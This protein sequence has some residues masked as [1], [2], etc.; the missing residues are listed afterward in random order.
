MARKICENPRSKY[1][2]FTRKNKSVLGSRSLKGET[3][4]RT[5]QNSVFQHGFHLR[6]DM[7]RVFLPQRFG[8]APPGSAGRSSWETPE[9][10][11][12][13]ARFVALQSVHTRTHEEAHV[14]V[15]FD[16]TPGRMV[17]PTSKP[18]T[19]PRLRREPRVCRRP[20]SRSAARQREDSRIGI[21][22][23]PVSSSSSSLATSK[24]AWATAQS[25]SSALPMRA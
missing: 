12:P 24:S 3:A 17:N 20:T 21:R 18:L 6:T 10:A 1:R 4:S 8:S 22:H 11:F 15:R 19:W 25:T 14:G 5:S 23:R 9:S 7:S 2:I 16:S 13:H